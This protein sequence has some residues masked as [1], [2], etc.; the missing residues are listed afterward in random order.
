MA[1]K[2]VYRV[3]RYV[4]LSNDAYVLAPN[5]REAERIVDMFDLCVSDDYEYVDDS[6]DV[7]EVPEKET[8][9][10][11]VFDPDAEEPKE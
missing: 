1:D 6:F 3:R 4:T 11:E 5:E 7:E 9:G 8:E 2:K 10:L